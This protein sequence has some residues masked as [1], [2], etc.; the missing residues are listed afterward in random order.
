[1]CNDSIVLLYSLLTTPPPPLS[2]RQKVFEYQVALR[3][4]Q[5]KGSAVR[6]QFLLRNQLVCAYRSSHGS[7]HRC[8]HRDTDTRP[9]NSAHRIAY[10]L[11]SVQGPNRGA[12]QLLAVQHPNRCSNSRPN[13]ETNDDTD[14]APLRGKCSRVPREQ[15]LRRRRL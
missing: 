8:A 15:L 10:Q 7:A 4:G 12:Y 5:D 6:N 1:M 11:S 9:N 3:L 2:F 14:Q 13:A